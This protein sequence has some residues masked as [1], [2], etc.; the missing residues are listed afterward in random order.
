MFARD[1]GTRHIRKADF[2]RIRILLSHLASEPSHQSFRL[3]YNASYRWQAPHFVPYV[4]AQLH[5]AIRKATFEGSRNSSKFRLWQTFETSLSLERF[6]VAPFNRGWLCHALANQFF[7]ESIAVSAYL[8]KSIVFLI[9]RPQYEYVGL[10]ALH[11]RE[12]PARLALPEFSLNTNA[13]DI[14]AGP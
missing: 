14:V 4:T 11:A 9:P 2:A 8:R 10:V 6:A 1:H 5:K 3:T 7:G 13:P 12:T